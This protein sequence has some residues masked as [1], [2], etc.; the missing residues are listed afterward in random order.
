MS[1]YEVCPVCDGE[2]KHVNPAID[3]NGITGSEMAEILAD[4]PDFLDDYMEGMYDVVCRC[5]EGRRVVLIEDNV[6]E[7]LREAADDRRIAAL[8]DGDWEAYSHARDWRYGY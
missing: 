6:T 3:G 2:G 7:K 5:C 4:D 8:E 1:K